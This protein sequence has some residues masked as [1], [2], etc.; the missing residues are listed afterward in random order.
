MS[1]S[2]SNCYICKN[3]WLGAG[4]ICDDCTYNTK[5]GLKS[6]KQPP[7]SCN[8]CGGQHHTLDCLIGATGLLSFMPKYSPYRARSKLRTGLT[9]AAPPMKSCPTCKG[10]YLLESK[11]GSVCSSCRTVIHNPCRNCTSTNTTGIKG[12]SLQ[13]VECQDCLFIE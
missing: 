3:T 1:I 5:F 11:A 12:D 7:L 2:A 6:P 10:N 13:F 8:Y 4:P 9:T